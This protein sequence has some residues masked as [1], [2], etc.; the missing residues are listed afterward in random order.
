MKIKKKLVIITLI[1]IFMI[2]PKNIYASNEP[3]YADINGIE[4]AN[5]T[6]NLFEDAG[7]KIIGI[8]QVVGII[9]SIIC[10]MLIGIKYIT[11]SVE[12]KA[13]YKKTLPIYLLGVCLTFG[14]FSFLEVIYEW[15][16]EIIDVL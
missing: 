13:E 14:I 6:T 9:S 15:V 5:G 1:L 7:N 3:R 16:T 4:I 2:I 11:S 8:I 12:G 10:L